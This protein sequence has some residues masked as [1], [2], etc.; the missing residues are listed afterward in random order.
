MRTRS[1]LLSGCAVAALSGLVSPAAADSSA[2]NCADAPYNGTISGTVQGNVVVTAYPSVCLITGT[3]HGNVSA[4]NESEQ[5]Q[6]GYPPVT[7]I[8]VVGGRVNGNVLSY[9]ATC[10]M[11]WLRD[12]AAVDGNVIHRS[13]GNLGFLGNTSGAT[14]TGAAILQDGHLFATGSSTTNRIAGNLICNGGEPQG[15][16]AGTATDWDA[17]GSTDGSI[18]GRYIDC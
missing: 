2:V 12:G 5:C 9:G 14:V 17:D 3:V 7:A 10:V 13:D 15:A 11:I 6:A 4:R 8:N 18:G 1:M 16:G